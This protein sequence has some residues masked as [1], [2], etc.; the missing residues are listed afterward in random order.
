MK[1]D[2]QSKQK[3]T[4][5][6]LTRLS[7]IDSK[8]IKQNINVE[9]KHEEIHGDI[10]F[11]HADGSRITSNFTDNFDSIAENVELWVQ[12]GKA[13]I[14]IKVIAERI[15][16]IDYEFNVWRKSSAIVTRQ[17]E[18]DLQANEQRQRLYAHVMKKHGKYGSGYQLKGS[19]EDDT[20][21][22]DREKVLNSRDTFKL[23]NQ[24]L[25]VA[26]D[27]KEDGDQEERYIE[28]TERNALQR[29]NTNDF[30]Y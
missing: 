25:D 10:D 2:S 16:P 19:Y 8:D 26:E 17:I 5:T 11:I 12:S 20:Y 6:L 23:F 21:I 29:P 7:N 18:L 13:V 3:L 28:K 15:I 1:K 24:L 27:S 14:M 30:M 9:H 22:Q 4:K